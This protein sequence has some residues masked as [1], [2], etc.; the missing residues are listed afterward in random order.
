M[1]EHHSLRVEDLSVSYIVA[2]VLGG[3][4]P[5]GAHSVRMRVMSQSAPHSGRYI[6]ADG[7]CNSPQLRSH[8]KRGRN[9]VRL[10]LLSVIGVALPIYYVQDQTPLNAVPAASH[11]AIVR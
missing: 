7:S 8:V 6:S 2:V 10:M 4:V 9:A 3:T 11:V 5:I 1:V